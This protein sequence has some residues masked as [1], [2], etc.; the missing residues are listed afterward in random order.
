MHIICQQLV[1]SQLL[2]RVFII[3]IIYSLSDSSSLCKMFYFSISR[4]SPLI[5]IHH[6]SFFQFFIYI[7]LFFLN[8]FSINFSI[9]S[10]II[11]LTPLQSSLQ[12]SLQSIFIH[13]FIQLSFIFYSFI[14][15]LLSLYHLFFIFIVCLKVWCHLIDDQSHLLILHF[16]LYLFRD[17]LFLSFDIVVAF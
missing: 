1:L 4:Y 2:S 10:S 11:S 3:R 9:N 13:F 15:H 12:S 8:L 17:A 6:F 14:F 16:I 7:F 5:Y